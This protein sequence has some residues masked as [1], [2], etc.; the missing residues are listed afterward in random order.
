[1]PV[2]IF[3][4][5]SYPDVNRFVAALIAGMEFVPPFRIFDVRFPNPSYPYVSVHAAGVLPTV[6]AELADVSRFRAPSA[7]EVFQVH[8]PRNQQIDENRRISATESAPTYKRAGVSTTPAP[9]IF[10]TE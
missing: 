8:S 9:Q 4:F 2:G 5:A 1:M 3:P 6:G 7:P 10:A